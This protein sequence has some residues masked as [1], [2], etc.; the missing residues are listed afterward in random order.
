MIRCLHPPRTL[1]AAWP[2]A[3]GAGARLRAGRRQDRPLHPAQRHRLGRRRDHAQ[4]AAGAGQGAGPPGHR[5]QPARRRRHRRPAG[6]G[7]FGARRLHAQRGVEQRRHL[8]ERLQ[9]A[10]VRHAGRLHADRDRRLHADGAGGQPA[11]CR[12]SNSKEFVALLK[13]KPATCTYAS[14]GNGTILH[15]AARDV[16]RRGRRAGAAHSVQGRRPDGHRPDRRPG[17]LRHRGA[18]Q[19]AAHLK[20]GALRAI[21][22]GDRAARAGGAGDPDL[23]RAG[24]ARLRGRG[25]VRGDRPEG[26]AARPTCKRVHA[27]MV[28]AFADP[29]VKEAMAKQ[30]NVINIAP[31][32]KAHALL[33]QRDGA[34]TRSW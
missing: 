24:P 14:G 10:A 25:L 32:D 11:R 18:A 13:A 27:A 15:L 2:A 19:R 29:A 3:A 4:R 6:A 1:L 9:V 33:P 30:G 31:A 22:V 28:A 7:A 5:R 23:R 34:S 16:P 20:S 26:P 21:G 17:R 12:P 8:S